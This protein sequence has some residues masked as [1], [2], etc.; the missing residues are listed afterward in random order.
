MKTMILLDIVESLR[1]RWFLIYTLVFGGLVVLF[2]T[3]GVT[4]SH[5]MGFS[6]LSR[7]LLAYL[8]VTIIVLPI[9]V[10][11]STV[12]SISAERESHVLEYMLSFPVSK[13]DYYWGKWIGRLI[14]VYLPI[15]GAMVLAVFIGLIKGLPIP[16][17]LLLLY[18]ALLF[19]LC[20]FF[21]GVSFI[22]STMLKN[23]E[24]AMGSAFFIWLACI[25]LM[26]VVLL[27]VMMQ[28]GVN[29]KLIVLL[30]FL[31]P[32]EG[33][34]IGSFLLFDPELTVLGPSAYYVLDTF[35]AKSFLAFAILYPILSGLGLSML[36][37]RYFATKDIL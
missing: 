30:S 25:L 8:Q 17:S 26:D 27:G 23:S 18:S 36:G 24:M 3:T 15:F 21:L 35:G 7:L 2:F 29:E 4:E 19:A 1:S 14:V 34:R 33:F 28:Q 20:L 16:V 31:N 9:F 10:L 32:I 37:Y 13:R 5:V 12:R 22:L 11:I 6:G